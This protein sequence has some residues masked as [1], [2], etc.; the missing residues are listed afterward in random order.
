VNLLVNAAQAIPVGAADRNEIRVTLSTDPQGWAVASVRDTGA[1]IPPEIRGR[2]F[3]P[4]FTT[5][6]VGEGSGLG[7]SISQGIVRGLGG[8]IT[9]ESA[10]GQG[11]TFSLRLPPCR[12]E[13]GDEAPPEAPAL[14]PPPRAATL[15][16]VDDEPLVTSALTRALRPWH[17]V[18]VSGSGRDALARLRGG[19]RF[20]LILCDLMMPEMTGMELHAELVRVAPDQAARLVFVTGGAF[21]EGARSFLE[22]WTGP[23]LEKPVD[24]EK[25]R[26]IIDERVA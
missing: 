5:K 16:L 14:T 11:S 21:S 9:V 13:A 1:G 15:L 25:L 12:D 8:E 4:F 22:S 20:D 10:P 3:D 24:L 19:E 7:L 17:R 26:R 6:P 23:W 2:L 18:T